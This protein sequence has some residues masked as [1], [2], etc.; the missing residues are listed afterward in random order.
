MFGRLMVRHDK[1]IC[2]GVS[3]CWQFYN[4][5]LF[6]QL[7]YFTLILYYYFELFYW[8]NYIFLIYFNLDRRNDIQ[9]ISDQFFG[10]IPTR[11][12]FKIFRNGNNFC[13]P[14][15]FLKFWNFEIPNFRT[16]QSWSFHS[17][18]PIT[19]LSVNGGGVTSPFFDGCCTK[20]SKILKFEIMQPCLT[21]IIF[22]SGQF[23]R[24]PLN[25]NLIV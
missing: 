8:N 23:L 7:K 9:F 24:D 5:V 10:W 4:A 18:L 14:N 16:G 25:L 2:L 3:F 15:F 13:D 11:N 1:I 20:L 17:R 19:N 12:Q 6:N 21:A 22:P